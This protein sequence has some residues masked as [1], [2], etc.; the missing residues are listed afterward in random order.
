MKMNYFY[1]YTTVYRI[2]VELGG[3]GAGTVVSKLDIKIYCIILCTCKYTASKNGLLA[4]NI[5]NCI[6][7]INIEK[8]MKIPEINAK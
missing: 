5:K 1:Y 7:T 4:L 2:K 3:S 8:N 6:T